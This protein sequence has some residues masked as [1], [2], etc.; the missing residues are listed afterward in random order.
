MD[1]LIAT[2]L[3]FPSFTAKVGIRKWPIAGLTADIV[4]NTLFINRV[5]THEERQKL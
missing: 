5:G 4:F 1:I 2:I 3:K